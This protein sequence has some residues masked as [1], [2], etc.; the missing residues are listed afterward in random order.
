[1]AIETN[2]L[3]TYDAKG[4]REDL[5]DVIYNI[6]PEDTP[7]MQNAGRATAKNTLFEWQIDTLASADGA[8]AQIE[9]D[10]VDNSAGYAASDPTTRVG[11]Y[12]QI[13]R[14]TAIVSGTQEAVDKAGRRKEMAY[15]L[16]K[17]SKELKRDIE[18]ICLSNQ[19][20]VAGNSSTAR[21]TGSLLAWIKTNVDKAAG[22]GATPS[23]TT[24]PNAA[25]T[26]GT[27]RAS[28][29][30]IIKAVI[31]KVWAAGGQPKILMCGPI[32]KQNISAFSGIAEARVNVKGAAPTTI[33]GAAD[34]YVSDFG[35]VSVVPNR[36]QRER[37]LL[38]I[39]PEYVK[40]AYLRPFKTVDMS[41]TGD[42][43]KKMMLTE[44]GL[45]V[46][47]EQALGIAADINASLNA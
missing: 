1:M 13:S 16:A 31:Q 5:S 35:N 11:N 24:T 37:D 41:V 15:Q 28:S 27:Q 47:N 21:T 25:R 36:F 46:T 2:T 14:K 7:F 39:D 3:T 34:V 43:E 44:W 33:I 9:G 4:I 19:A 8:N 26:D 23:Y 20:C 30:A 10:D 40:I 12:C 45:K 22:D 17:R 18:T 6:S 32:N 29:E 42:S 38:F